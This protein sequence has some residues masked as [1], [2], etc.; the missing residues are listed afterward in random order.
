ML[1]L[2]LLG[3]V[4]TSHTRCCQSICYDNRN[5]SITLTRYKG[6]YLMRR[7]PHASNGSFNP[8]AI[9][10]EEAHI[11][12]GNINNDEKEKQ[13]KKTINEGDATDSE[14]LSNPNHF[15]N[16][17]LSHAGKFSCAVDCFLELCFSVFHNDLHNINR[18]EFFNI[19]YESCNIRL[20]L[21]AVELVRQP[22]WSWIKDHCASFSAM[23]ADAVFSDIFTSRTFGD[24]S[25]DL[26]S[27]FL[28]KQCNQTLCTLCGSQIINNASIIVLYIRCTAANAYQFDNFVSQAVTP[29]A[30]RLFCGSCNQYSEDITV[31]QHFVTL[32]TFLSIELTSNFINQISFPLIMEVLAN[33]YKLSAVVRCSGS[34]FTIAIER[35]MQWFYFDDLCRSVRKYSSFHEISNMHTNGWFFAVYKKCHF[36]FI[37]NINVCQNNS[38]SMDNDNIIKANNSGMPFSPVKHNM[39]SL[40]VIEKESEIE[41][42][43]KRGATDIDLKFKNTKKRN[44]NAYMN[45]YKK[46]KRNH[47]SDSDKVLRLELQNSYMKQYKRV[48]KSNETESEKK[49]RKETQNAYMKKF[50]MRKNIEKVREDSKKDGV[51]TQMKDVSHSKQQL[52]SK[53]KNQIKD[54]SHS[55]QLSL[56]KETYLSLFDSQSNGPIHVQEWAKKI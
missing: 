4:L 26:K 2:L 18:N 43:R 52:N 47:E 20:N 37:S 6:R 44:R 30:N 55:R 33:H 13:L 25:E 39:S 19:V 49:I 9:S 14:G 16:Y 15:R 56:D 23:T 34:H 8:F 53:V 32:P 5:A 46:M 24:I 11:V 10:N 38:A 3:L 35:E 1:S 17:C 21:G 40:N 29:T 36:S 48:K 27:M 41:K 54:M 12:N 50:R 51:K 31:M 42:L 28:V 22:V 7:I 45:E